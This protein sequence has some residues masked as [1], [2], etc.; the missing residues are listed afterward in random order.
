MKKIKI[1]VKVV[2]NQSLKTIFIKRGARID[3]DS[4][5][6]EE[7][8]TLS[9]L[10]AKIGLRR[11]D[12]GFACVNEQIVHDPGRPLKDGDTIVLYPPLAGG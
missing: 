11:F 2:L 8:Q 9:D 4:V 6:M 3:L 12:A 10:Y 7:G 5:E 1:R